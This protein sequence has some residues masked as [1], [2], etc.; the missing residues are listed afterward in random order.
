L[1]EVSVALE[2]MR[3]ER[4]Q[5]HAQIT[6]LQDQLQKATERAERS[7][8]RLHE[9][10]MMLAQVSRDALTA[11]SRSTATEIMMDGRSVLRLNNPIKSLHEPV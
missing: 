8:A 2:I 4:D 9:V 5:L 11:P 1:F 6:L 10:T 3:F 7:E